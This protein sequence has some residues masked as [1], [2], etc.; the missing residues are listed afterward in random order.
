MKDNDDPEEQRS[1][2]KTINKRKLFQPKQRTAI[3]TDE[4]ERIH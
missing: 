2:Q 3:V 1:I 4:E